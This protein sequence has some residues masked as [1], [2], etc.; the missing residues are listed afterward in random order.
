MIAEEIE[1]PF[2]HDIDDLPLDTICERICVTV[3]EIMRREPTKT[4]ES[5]L[6]KYTSSFPAP[7]INLMS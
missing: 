3:H 6:L 2:G 5:D 7:K 1:D 4:K